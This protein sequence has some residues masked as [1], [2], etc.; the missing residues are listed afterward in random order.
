MLENLAKEVASN[1]K[2]PLSEVIEIIKLQE[3]VTKE[4]I[5]AGE[6]EIR[7]CY[8]GRFKKHGRKT[9]SDGSSGS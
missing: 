8:I 5:L 7:L 9:K 6:E 1:L 3:Q 2:L 4:K